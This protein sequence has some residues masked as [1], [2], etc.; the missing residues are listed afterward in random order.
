MF[1]WTFNDVIGAAF[2]ALFAAV[3]VSFLVVVAVTSVC[4]RIRNIFRNLW[5]RFH[6]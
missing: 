1:V 5:S 6:G 4:R 3:A 2:L